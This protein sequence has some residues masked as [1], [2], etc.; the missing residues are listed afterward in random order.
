MH[1][2]VSGRAL[3]IAMLDRLIGRMKALPGVWF[4]TCEQVA[5]HVSPPI[6]PARSTAMPWKERYTISDERSSLDSDMRWPDGKRCCFRVVV[7]LA[8][9]SGPDGI[10]PAGPHHARRLLRHAWR[11]RARWCGMLNRYDIKATFAVPAVIAEIQ[12]TRCAACA[13][14][15]TRSPP[16][17]SST[18]T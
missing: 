6:R 16:T 10:K 15:A 4:P 14:R 3:R 17:A 12:A 5:R 7:D 2:F 9:A 1:P 13:T 18:R 11:A 8:P